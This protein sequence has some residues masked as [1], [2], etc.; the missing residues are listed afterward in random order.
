[1]PRN[2]EDPNMVAW[3][4]GVMDDGDKCLTPNC[5]GTIGMKA[6]EN[7]S[8][9]ISPPCSACVEAPFECKVCGWESPPNK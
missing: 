1:M 6:V 5:T 9:H 2:E 4:L 8:C 3:N 7:C